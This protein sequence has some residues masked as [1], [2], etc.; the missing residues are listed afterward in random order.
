ML[1]GGLVAVV[2]SLSN[3]IVT[4]SSQGL[5]MGGMVGVD[6]AGAAIPFTQGFS[7]GIKGA[8]TQTRITLKQLTYFNA[9]R[10][11]LSWNAEQKQMDPRQGLGGARYE[12][13]VGRQITAGNTDGVDLVDPEVGNVS[14]KGP[15]VDARGQPLP[16]QDI[17][18]LAKSTIKDVTRNT[19][20]KR[21]VVD[22]LGLSD[23]QRATLKQ[24]ISQGVG[25][26]PRKDIFYI[27]D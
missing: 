16:F 2:S 17:N 4:G 12:G 5:I 21:V 19:A 14:L 7:S 22:T 20:T 6:M 9:R 15:L 24:Q 25:P 23:Q 1:L 18:G 13:K 27:D 26:T 8:T 10:I 11:D 3:W